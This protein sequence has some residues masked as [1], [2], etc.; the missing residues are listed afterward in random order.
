MQKKWCIR[1]IKKFFKI[2]YEYE[3]YV[4]VR[5]LQCL[6]RISRREVKHEYSRPQN[7]NH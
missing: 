2:F 3:R 5:F 7:G 1:A 4:R 6:W